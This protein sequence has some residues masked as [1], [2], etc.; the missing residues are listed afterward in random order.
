ME[1][2][3]LLYDIFY[4]GNPYISFTA[5]GSPLFCQHIRIENVA[6][7][8]DTHLRKLVADL[9]TWFSIHFDKLNDH[10]ERLLFSSRVSASDWKSFVSEVPIPN[11]LVVSL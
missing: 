4:N 2:K 6:R 9:D 5:A 7:N 11:E 1:L 8:R 3:L 10:I